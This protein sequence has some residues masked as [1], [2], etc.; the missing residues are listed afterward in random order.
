M[1]LPPTVIS[2]AVALTSCGRRPRMLSYLSR[3]ASVALSVRSFTPTTSMSASDASTA[4]KKLRPIRPKPLMPT[5]MVTGPISSRSGPPAVS[6]R[7]GG[8]GV[9]RPLEPAVDDSS[10]P[11]RRGLQDLTARGGGHDEECRCR[12]PCRTL[13][14]YPSA[15]RAARVMTPSAARHGSTQPPA[16]DT[17]L[18]GSA[19]PPAGGGPPSYQ[20][21]SMSGRDGRFGIRDAEVAGPLVGQR[22]QP[23]DPPGDGVLGQRRVGQ[24][25]QLLQRR[26]PVLQPQ[27]PGRRSGGWA[28][29]RRGS[30][31]PG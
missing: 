8:S 17:S 10:R 7:A 6:Q 26:L 3:W 20:T 31:A 25:T 1:V 22:Q 29:R 18:P 11:P 9:R 30:P 5:R 24:R 28:R 19:A 23:A 14:P 13:R 12:P 2:S 27:P 16:V 15:R 21:T 4:R